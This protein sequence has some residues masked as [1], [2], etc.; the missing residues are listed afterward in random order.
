MEAARTTLF[1]SA[2]PLGPHPH[3]QLLVVQQLVVKHFTT[4]RLTVLTLTESA[5]EHAVAP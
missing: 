1:R 3:L 5:V 4:S 2:V